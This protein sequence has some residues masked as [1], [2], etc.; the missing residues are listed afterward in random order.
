[1]ARPNI[2]FAIVGEMHGTVEEPRLFGDIVESVARQ[3]R[4]VVVGLEFESGTLADY[5]ASD[6]GPVARRKLIAQ[7][8]WQTADGRSSR[9]MLALVARLQTMSRAHGGL[10]LAAIKPVMNG[11]AQSQTPYERAM[12]ANIRAAARDSRATVLVLVG[13]IHARR[14]PFPATTN[15]KAFEPMAMHLPRDQTLSVLF[16]TDGGQAWN[17]QEDC[18]PHAL[19]ADHVALL[20]EPAALKQFHQGYDLLVPAG[21]VSASPPASPLAK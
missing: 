5:L 12:A 8:D 13:N 17:C 9:A 16:T 11:H 15:T 18:G 4:P 10:A 7:A 14:L 20:Q 3:R 19:G 6:G 2:R 1:L 21:K